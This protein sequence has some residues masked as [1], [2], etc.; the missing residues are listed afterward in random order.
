[1][2]ANFFEWVGKPN[3][4]GP[5]NRANEEDVTP[6]PYYDAKTMPKFRQNPRPSDV[7]NEEYI[8]TTGIDSNSGGSAGVKRKRGY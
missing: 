8:D 4:V 5:R 1:M 2:A 7:V 6:T 3:E